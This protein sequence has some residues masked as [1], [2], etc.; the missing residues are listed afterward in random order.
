MIPPSDRKPMADELLLLTEKMLAAAEASRWDELDALQEEREQV[1]AALFADLE[2]SQLGDLAWI[3]T[4]REVQKINDALMQVATFERDRTGHE[5]LSF[6]NARKAESI[7]A[8][9]LDQGA[10]E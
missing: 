2:P 3:S 5:L 7:Y 10:Y 4:I 1:I 8:S 9:A 6:R